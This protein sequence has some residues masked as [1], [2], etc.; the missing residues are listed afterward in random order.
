[1]NAARRW[2]ERLA[3][4]DASHATRLDSRRAPSIGL[5]KDLA[6]PSTPPEQSS[7]THRG[8]SRTS[9]AKRTSR[10]VF[11]VPPHPDGLLLLGFAGLLHP[12]AD[13]EVH[14]VLCSAEPPH[15][16]PKT[17][18]PHR[19]IT[20]QSIPLSSSRPDVTAR[21]MPPRR[22]GLLPARP[23]GLAPLE[24]PL[25]T[26]TVADVTMPVA[27]LGFP[28][29]NHVHVRSRSAAPPDPRVRSRPLNSPAPLLLPTSTRPRPWP[30]ARTADAC[31][32]SL[33]M[34]RKRTI[35][36]KA[37]EQ[38]ERHILPVSQTVSTSEE[39]RTVNPAAQGADRSRHHGQHIPAGSCRRSNPSASRRDQRESEPQAGAGQASPPGLPD[40]WALLVEHCLARRITA[41]R[42]P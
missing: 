28:F 22:Y 24:S 37:L 9:A 20:L 27:L 6:S 1:V 41:P 13:H 15:R 14:R 36:S 42:P 18:T 31:A 25:H 3:L 19:C 16:N 26:H 34:P 33:Q 39:N 29:W 40:T 8:V 17:N 30:T 21:P 23:R 35:R 10:A 12:A 38:L 11:V 7:P 4:E 5:S 2:L 32:T